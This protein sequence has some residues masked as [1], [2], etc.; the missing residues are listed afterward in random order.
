M[1]SVEAA[2][3]Y[4]RDGAKLSSLRRAVEFKRL[5]LCSTN[6]R[7]ADILALQMYMERDSIPDEPQFMGA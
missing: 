1:A 5:L 2:R 6:C 3:E 7:E 4:M